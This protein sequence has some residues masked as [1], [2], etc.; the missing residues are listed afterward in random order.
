MPSFDRLPFADGIAT[1]RSGLGGR[2]ATAQQQLTVLSSLSEPLQICADL[3]GQVCL[4]GSQ[5]VGG[6]FVAGAASQKR[7]T[8]CS[9][10]MCGWVDGVIRLGERAATEVIATEAMSDGLGVTSRRDLAVLMSARSAAR[11]ND[12]EVDEDPPH[13]MVGRGEAKML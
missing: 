10:A 7:G 12:L 1:W 2:P 3:G 5:L 11:T 9:A 8:E 6:V 4:P 13:T